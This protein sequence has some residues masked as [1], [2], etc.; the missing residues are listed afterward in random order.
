MKTS[1]AHLSDLKQAQ[2]ADVVALR[3]EHVPVEMIV[4]FGSHARGDTVDDFQT[5]YRSDFDVLV[6]VK[7]RAVIERHA[8]WHRVEHLAR[9]QLGHTVLSL[10]RGGR[11]TRRRTSEGTGGRAR[12]CPH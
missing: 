4:L 1:L 11:G 3:R 10:T 8:A 5:G 7:N 6:V 2:L 9:E 12:P